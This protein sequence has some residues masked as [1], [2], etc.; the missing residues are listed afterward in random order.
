MKYFAELQKADFKKQPENFLKAVIIKPQVFGG[1]INTYKL[2]KAAKGFNVQNVISNIFETSLSISAI[3]VFLF[4]TGQNSVPAGLDT[5][6]S[7]VEDVG[8]LNIKSKNSKISVKN[9]YDNLRKIDYSL[10]VSMD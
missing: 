3:A 5:V 10:V 9:A 8:C 2:I 6:D 7:F 1:F 4:I